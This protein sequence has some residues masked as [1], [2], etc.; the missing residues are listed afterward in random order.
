MLDDAVTIEG[1]AG[2]HLARS[3]RLRP[4]EIVTAADGHGRWRQYSVA[5]A[6]R[7]RLLLDATGPLVAEPVL[8]PSLSIAFAITKGAKP[9]LVVQ[10]LTEIGVDRI[11]LV[12]AER[13]VPRWNSDRVASALTRLERVAFEAASQCR[14]SRLPSVT[15]LEAPVDLA[16]YPGLMVADPSGKRP[17]EFAAPDADEWLLA[18]GPEGGFEPSELAALP[19]PRLALGPFVLR[20]ETAAIAGA[21]VLTSRRS[22]RS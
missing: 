17:E 3:R 12:R 20:A 21:V 15:G 16:S 13:N 4:G 9:D 6:D 19:G 5:E 7:E 22:T 11:V 8:E 10:K 18:V 2:R 14:R 1:A